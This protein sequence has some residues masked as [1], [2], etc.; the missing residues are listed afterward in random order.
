MVRTFLDTV[1]HSPMLLLAAI[2]LGLCIFVGVFAPWVAPM[3]P[4]VQDLGN[5]LA[6]PSA[7][8]LLGSDEYGRDLFSRLV[9]GMRNSLIVG[10]LVMVLS[11]LI[12]S[13]LGIV[14]GYAGGWIDTALMRIVD[15]TMAFPFL[16][17]ALGLIAAFGAGLASTIVALTIAFAPIYARIVRSRVIV[18]R[19]EAY[20]D[21]A[22]LMGVPPGRIARRHILPNVTGAIVVQGA[23]T[24][25]FAVLSEASLSFVGLG[26]PPPAPSFGN[27]IA[28]GRDYMRDA[29]W[30][31]NSS[32]IAIVI[33][34]FSLLVLADG[35]R[36]AVD[37]YHQSR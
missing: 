6:P 36:D 13:F 12:G 29:P 14:A 19:T 32:G 1:R 23:L 2:L 26:V 27:I 24:F 31:V 20:V 15:V 35:M 8:F 4:T 11:A 21:A 34:V 16:V 22:V 9:F 3:D 18:V 33:V 30:I 10:G 7:H 17:L 5:S 28:A 37:P 25:A